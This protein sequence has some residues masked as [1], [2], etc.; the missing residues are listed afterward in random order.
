MK[1]QTTQT[2]TQKSTTAKILPVS[3]QQI[4]LP[5][6]NEKSF[7]GQEYVRYGEDN[8]FPQFLQMLSDRSALH[9]AIITTKVDYSYGYGLTFDE[10]SDETLLTKAFIK[11]PNPYEDLN[12]IYKKCLYDYILY[13]AFALNVIWDADGEHIAEIYHCDVAKLRSGL[14]DDFGIVHEYFY[15]NNWRKTFTKDY[16]KIKAF[17]KQDRKGSQI[18]YAKEYRPGI[19]YYALP[20]YCG[21]L[22]SIA[23]D[24]EISNFHLSH[25]LNGMA[26]SKMITF[27]DGVPSEEEER[28]IKRQIE[29]VYTGSDNAG[30]FV[31]S[32]VNSPEKAPQIN[33]L[34]GDNLDEE[35]IQLESSVLNQ[36]LAGHKVTSPLLVGLRTDNNGLGSNA[37]EI[38]ESFRVFVNTVIKPIQEEVVNKLNMLIRY[39]KGYVR[40]ELEPTVNTPIEFTYSEATLTQILTKNEL[41]ERIGMLPLEKNDTENE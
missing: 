14:K 30:R 26:P 29:N 6:F 4:S 33:T 1:K 11:H 20:S 31:L 41:R 22:N 2:P 25:I 39:T 3:C 21:C 9:N 13:G 34:G 27:V 19:S 36:I 24:I 28:A 8:C 38:L 7:S 35:F 37:N 17:T 18:L 5:V 12:S 10:E 16:K 32:F 15:S 23:T 40:G